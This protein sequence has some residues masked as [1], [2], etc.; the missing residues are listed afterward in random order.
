MKL[1]KQMFGGRSRII[2]GALHGSE[3][4]M[5]FASQSAQ[6]SLLCPLCCLA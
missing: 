3:V 5:E 2:F 6:N 1:A 4:C